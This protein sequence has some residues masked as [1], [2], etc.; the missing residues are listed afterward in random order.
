MQRSTEISWF[1]EDVWGVKIGDRL[2]GYKAE[3]TFNSFPQAMHW[4][5]DKALELYPDS[6]F[7]KD[8][9]R[10][11]P[12]YE[13]RPAEAG[14]GPWPCLEVDRIAAREIPPPIAGG[15]PLTR[16]PGSRRR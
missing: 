9:R 6:E 14:A 3:A 4:L 11:H 5:R 2:N 16:R 8:Y 15:P 1:F 12:D 13:P 10:T 7:A